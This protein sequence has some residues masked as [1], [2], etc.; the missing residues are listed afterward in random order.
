MQ[1]LLVDTLSLPGLGWV[2]AVTVVAG[3]VYGFA[4]FGAALVFMPVATVFVTVEMAVAA[5][6]VSA[7][8]SFVTVVPRA[9]READRPSVVTMILIA[10]AALPVGLWILRTNDVTTMRWAV[11]AVTTGTLVAL[12]CGW[13]YRTEPSL[14]AR[15]GVAVATGVVG[16]ATGLVGPIMVLFQLSGQDSVARSRA[17]AL[18][19]LTITG[20]MTAPMMAMQGMLAPEAVMLGLLLILPYGVAAR[21]GQGLFDPDAQALYRKVAYA[22]IAAAIVMGLPIYG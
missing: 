9:W 3:V 20:L 19:F 8:A 21:I 22:I 10:G 1:E 15:A 13:R 17:N 7:L 5:F 11:L 18:V 6:A 16:G 12:M 2:V 14:G 4:G